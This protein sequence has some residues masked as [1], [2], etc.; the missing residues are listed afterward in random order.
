[1]ANVF[2][3]IGALMVLFGL[4]I[5]GGS[6]SAIHEIEAGVAFVIAAILWGS[7][8][9]MGQIDKLR[10]SREKQGGE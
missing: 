9:I 2:W 6:K 7:A 3:L 10:N 8:G 1:M 4:L 5:F